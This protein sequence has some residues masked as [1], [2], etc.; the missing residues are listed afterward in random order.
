MTYEPDW[1]DTHCPTCDAPE[2]N[3]TP[4]CAVVPV[5]VQ[6]CQAEPDTIS[7]RVPGAV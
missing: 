5:R 6:H 3:H 7:T 4:T 1:Y 2:P